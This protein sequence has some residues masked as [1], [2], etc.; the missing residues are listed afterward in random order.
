MLKT[1]IGFRRIMRDP[2]F[3]WRESNSHVEG[4]VEQSGKA[5]AFGV[6]EPVQPY[7]CATTVVEEVLADFFQFPDLL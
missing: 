6:F 2:G 1:L 5:L 4:G 3:H 7:I